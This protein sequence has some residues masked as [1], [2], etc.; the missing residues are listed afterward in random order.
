MFS[1]HNLKNV[2]ILM[3]PNIIEFNGNTFDDLYMY[4][5]KNDTILVTSYYFKKVIKI[6]KPKKIIGT[7]IL[8]TLYLAYSNKWIVNYQHLISDFY[9]YLYYYKKHHSH[10]YIGIPKFIK[11]KPLMELLEIMEIPKENIIWLKYNI[12]YHIAN[13]ITYKYGRTLVTSELE[14]SIEPL[15]FLNDKLCSLN[16]NCKNNNINL[17]MTVSSNN[18]LTIANNSILYISR[19]DTTT[20]DNNNNFAGKTRDI[21]NKSNV[22][23]Y[24][25]DNEIDIQSMS[26]YSIKEKNS[27]LSTY[28]TF[29]TLH[30]ANA[31]N[32]VFA[33]DIVNLIMLNNKK[34]VEYNKYFKELY[35]KMHKHPINL[36][37]I[38]DDMA[39]KYFNQPYIVNVK[40]LHSKL[41][42]INSSFKYIDEYDND[43]IFNVYDSDETFLKECLFKKLLQRE[44]NEVEF[45]VHLANIKK[46]GRQSVFYEFTGCYEYHVVNTSDYMKNVLTTQKRL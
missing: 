40:E 9:P 38:V 35:E 2:F 25:S 11:T 3:G 8:D 34:T 37:S 22:Y 31:I 15:K 20:K 17:G 32:L 41:I 24:L 19:D 26:Q 12:I 39:N 6:D 13:L 45:N 4:N 43:T 1:Q 29:I 30:G 46:R 16:T 14:W 36:I 23:K 28:N 33:K 44:P 7:F 21:L 10:L 18:Q 42:T 27:L 5:N